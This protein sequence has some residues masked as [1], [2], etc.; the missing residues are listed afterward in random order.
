MIENQNKNENKN[1]NDRIDEM[2]NDSETLILLVIFAVITIIYLKFD[3]F[4]A[5]VNHFVKFIPF[6]ILLLY[7]MRIIRF[8]LVIVII[9]ILC[10]LLFSVWYGQPKT[11]LSALEKEYLDRQEDVLRY[12]ELIKQIDIS[13]K[14][15]LLFYFNGKGNV[16]CAIAEKRFG[17]YK[18]VDVNGEL[19]PYNKNLR[20]GLYG[21]SYN[22]GEKWGYF[23][24][25]YDDTVERVVWNDTE[26]IRFSALNMEMVYAV[27]DGE[28]KGGVY[29]LYDA[30]GN[31]LEPIR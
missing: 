29:Y 2:I 14:E 21:F 16:N 23:G 10:G 22:K 13:P 18:I 12:S 8:K 1:I 30:N 9:F 24:I 11:P 7:K 17:G 4:G 26:G 27:G 20:V 31:E 19:A 25:I 15:T 6:Y 5:P 3:I 28:F